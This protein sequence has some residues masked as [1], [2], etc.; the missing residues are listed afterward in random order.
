[1]KI[2]KQNDRY[3]TINK[4][5]VALIQSIIPKVLHFSKYKDKDEKWI[6]KCF[7]HLTNKL[8][9]AYINTILVPIVRLDKKGN[10]V[11]LYGSIG[12]ISRL[13]EAES[14]PNRRGTG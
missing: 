13:G 4:E 7:K 14:K 12:Q 10:Y 9:R 6:Q 3:Q 1:M 2:N 8:T 11:P 5:R